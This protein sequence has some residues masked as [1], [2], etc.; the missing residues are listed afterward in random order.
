MQRTVILDN[1]FLNWLWKFDS[2]CQRQGFPP[3]QL[4]LDGLDHLLA[5][6]CTL[7]LPNEVLKEATHSKVG[8]LG[9][10]M[11][12]DAQPYLD[13]R[14]LDPDQPFAQGNPL[15]CAW[16]RNKLIQT[17]LVSFARSE[18]YL[19]AERSGALK[20]KICLVA[21]R[22]P[23]GL[24]G[25]ERLDIRPEIP[26]DGDSEIVNLAQRMHDSNGPEAPRVVVLSN[27]R[28]L[29]EDL[30]KLPG[31]RF[32]TF[33][34]YSYM[35]M[36]PLTGFTRDFHAFPKALA[37]FNT[38]D[39]KHILYRPSSETYTILNRTMKQWGLSRFAPGPQAPQSHAEGLAQRSVAAKHSEGRA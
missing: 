11:S 31:H 2:F 29:K 8:R 3:G 23:E 15:F 13:Q 24:G 27:D 1:C 21:D 17:E 6:G 10:S 20:G 18:D 22:A 5:R 26:M 30:D 19:K 35:E 7:L 38:V 14:L 33:N 39:D 25:V 28:G 32:N 37:M 4:P 16:L 36:L 34:G 9:M 12:L